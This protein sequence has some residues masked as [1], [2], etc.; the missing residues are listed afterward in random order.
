MTVGDLVD[1]ARPLG[2]HRDDLLGE[3][4]ERVAQVADRLDRAGL[5]PLGDQRALHEVAAELREQDARG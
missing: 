2:D 4:V 1:G 3:H 5:H